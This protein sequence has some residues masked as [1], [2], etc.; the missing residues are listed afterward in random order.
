VSQLLRRGYKV[1]GGVR[2]PDDSGKAGHLYQFVGANNLALI[3]AELTEPSS[4]DS[5]FVGCQVVLHTASPVTGGGD[6][7]E[8][9]FIEP[10]LQGTINVFDAIARS[11]PTVQTIVLT[12]SVSSISSN[13][14]LLPETHV[15]SEADW[16]PV[17]RLRELKRWYPLSKTLAEKAAWDHPLVT[18]GKV[19][20]VVINPGFV[21]GQI[22]SPKHISGTP[23]KWLAALKGEWTTIPNRCTIPVD[24]KDVAKAHIRAFEDPEA[25][26][27]YPCVMS[28]CTHQEVISAFN[29]IGTFPHLPTTVEDKEFSQGVDLWDCKKAEKLIGGWRSL[30]E[31]CRDM[32][33]SYAAFNLID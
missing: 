9:G 7:P 8:K 13:A 26:G 22:T 25:Q 33:E 15:Y 23:S 24:V 3:K 32:A 20:L 16:S 29:R 31:T 14:G 30:D 6:D 1:Q 17:D 28:T 4:L 10:A 18:S 2:D 19:K 27:R 5:L 11:A 12:S 21:V